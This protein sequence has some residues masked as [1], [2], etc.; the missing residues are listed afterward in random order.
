MLQA[1]APETVGNGSSPAGHR[2]DKKRRDPRLIGRQ[3]RE[4]AM[5]R[6]LWVLPAAGV[7]ALGGAWAVAQ[8]A[9]PTGPMGQE[10]FVMRFH[11]MPGHRMICDNRDALLAGALAFLN[12]KI[13]ITTGEEPA[14]QRFS[15]AAK[16]SAAALDAP[17]DALQ[18]QKEPATLP[19][20]L[21]IAEKMATAH[22]QLIETLRPAVSD[23][24][25]AL[26]P[27]QRQR[28]DALPF[29]RR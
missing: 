7:L 17:C 28:L 20:R 1:P 9:A 13:E 6:W 16:R 25:S 21:A 12:A 8:T 3:R 10:R 14:W 18:H 22:L 23:L 19:D 5:K 15:E 29:G 4:R 27:E 11:A 2:P 24:Y 26:T